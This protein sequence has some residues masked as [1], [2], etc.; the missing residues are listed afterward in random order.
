MPVII[1]ISVSVVTQVWWAG[2]MALPVM[3]TLCIGYH[4]GKW[5]VRG[6]WMGLQAFVI[7]LGL[8]LTHFLVWYLFIPYV[9]VS[10]I[11]GG[12]LY[13]IDQF[14]GDFIFGSYLG[15]IIFLLH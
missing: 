4:D 13:N 6:L 2:L 7:G 14:I 12:T 11:L 1:G 3:G 9:L 15:S 10:A 5:L 8:F